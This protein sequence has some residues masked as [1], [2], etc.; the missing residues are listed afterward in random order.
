MK[1]LNRFKYWIM[2]AVALPLIGIG[3]MEIVE[4]IHPEDAKVN[5]D[6]DIS[7]KI[8]FT[9][10]TDHRSEI[11][12]AILAPKAWNIRENASLTLTTEGYVN[13]GFA[14][15]VDEQMTPIPEGAIEPGTGLPWPDAYQSQIGL[16]GNTGPME[17]VIFQSKTSFD[18]ND[19]RENGKEPIVGTV[20]IRLKTGPQAIKCFMGYGWCSL[21]KGFDVGG[22]DGKGSNRRYKENEKSKVL[23]VT[24]GDLPMLDYTV[25]SLVSTVPSVFGY[26]DIFSVKFSAVSGSTET[27]LNGQE[28]VVHA[29]T[30]RGDF[31][32]A[33]ELIADIVFHST[34]PQRELEKE[35]EV[36]VDEISDKTLME[37]ISETAYQKYIYPRHFFGLPAD[38]EIEATYFHFTNEDRSIVVT[39]PA[40]GEDFL[41]S[42]TVE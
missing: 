35:K 28:K 32:K 23:T 26:G 27:A 13:Q 25:E 30:L 6:I 41:V 11:A 39:D 10:E 4:I 18:V 34:F 15:V 36:I 19:Q 37:K 22:D 17:W 3:C 31:A 21:N 20:K 33:A 40:S 7:V 29:T 12:F 9:A 38:A 8:K 5:S 42:E 14:E 16:M 2:T 1:P 24:G